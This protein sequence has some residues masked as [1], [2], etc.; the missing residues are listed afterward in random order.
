MILPRLPKEQLEQLHLERKEQIIQAAIQ[1]FSRFGFSK[2][3]MSKIAD[4]VGISHGLIYH[5]FKSKEELFN[6]LIEQAAKTS[7]T[8][9]GNLV[10]QALGSTLDKIRLLTEI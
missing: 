9:I 1:V 3:N 2:T 5:Y 4:E 7:I 6:I 10:D 8:E